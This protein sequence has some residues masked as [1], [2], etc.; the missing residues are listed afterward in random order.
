MDW[1]MLLNR[2]K[3]RLF[4][5]LAKYVAKIKNII[6]YKLN[7]NL[8]WISLENPSLAKEI[9]PRIITI[10]KVFEFQKIKSAQVNLEVGVCFLRQEG[11]APMLIKESTFWQPI[12]IDLKIGL[13]PRGKIPKLELTAGAYI[14]PIEKNFYHWMFDVL[15]YV[16]AIHK[17]NENIILVGST[18]LSKFQL[19][20]FNEEMVITECDEVWVNANNVVLPLRRH[21]TGFPSVEVLRILRQHFSQMFEFEDLLE[22]KRIYVSRR[23]ASRAPS[24]EKEI[25]KSRNKNKV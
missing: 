22:R 1:Q 9:I 6:V 11:R 17:S 2:L 21:E 7:F 5:K 15:P 8:K 3:L 23:N 18:H 10:Q 20:S 24:N 19:E 25:E 4:L 12:D 14:V 16:I 13:I